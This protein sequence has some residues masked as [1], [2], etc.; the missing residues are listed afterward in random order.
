VLPL[1]S[2]QQ[3]LYVDGVSVERDYRG[4]AR[5]STPP[6]QRGASPSPAMTRDERKDVK[7]AQK[8]ERKELKET[9]KEERKEL[10]DDQKDAKKDR[11]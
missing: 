2:I 1:R 4:S 3:V 6:A 8:E 10:K 7:E 9:Q 11:K 5:A